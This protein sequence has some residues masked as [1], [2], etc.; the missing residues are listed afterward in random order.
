V[1]RFLAVGTVNTLVDYLLFI[2]LS[3]ALE[4]PLELVWIAK[5]IS[6]T[7][8][9]ALSFYLNRRWVFRSDGAAFHQAVR[10]VAATVVGVYVIQTGL[11]QL[12]SS[13]Y[14]GL[15]RE[16]H[17]LLAGV[18]AVAA[19][20]SIFTEAFAIKSA[21]FAVATSVSM[22]FNFAAYRW[23]VFPLGGYRDETVA[24]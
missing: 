23:W 19:F 14:P 4:L 8:A 16:F 12:L 11:T 1:R 5:A 15:G 22:A 9:I 13:G 21:A 20:P 10:F 6:G 17:D 2:A 3:R 18:G 24:P 7:V